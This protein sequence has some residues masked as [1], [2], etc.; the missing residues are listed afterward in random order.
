[1]K[2]DVSKLLPLI[3]KVLPY[4]KALAAVV[5]ALVTT[6]VCALDGQIDANDV[7]VIS[8]AWA[9]A[10]AVWRVTNKPKAE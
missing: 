4:L 7:A 5:G 10:Y 3:V 6:L 8:T 2:V 9:T 1:M